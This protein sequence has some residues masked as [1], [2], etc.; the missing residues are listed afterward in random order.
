VLLAAY[1]AHPERFVRKLPEPPRLSPTCEVRVLADMLALCRRAM[2]N[3]YLTCDQTFHHKVVELLCCGRPILC[4]PA[5]QA[6]ALTLTQ[7][8]GGDLRSCTSPA[9]IVNGLVHAEPTLNAPAG[10]RNERLRELTW[11][12]KHSSWIACCSMR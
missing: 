11:A 8:V 2:V 7:R 12:P 10:P 6:E 3:C 9:D 1:E 4:F 5:D